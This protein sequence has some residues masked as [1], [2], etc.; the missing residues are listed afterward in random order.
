MTS[1]RLA[2][3]AQCQA[4]ATIHHGSEHPAPSQRHTHTLHS[5][6]SAGSHNHKTARIRV[7]SQESTLSRLVM[8]LRGDVGSGIVGGDEAADACRRKQRE[9]DTQRSD[10]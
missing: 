2:L 1:L 3:S 8:L 5:V 7:F 9:E 4:N 6:P 10:S